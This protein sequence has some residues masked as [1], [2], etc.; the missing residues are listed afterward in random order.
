M[1][2]LY[3][4]I[5][6]MMTSCLCAREATSDEDRIFQLVAVSNRS[7]LNIA[8]VEEITSSSSGDEMR[9]LIKRVFKP[10]NGD[11]H[12]YYFRSAF[13]GIAK[14][15]DEPEIFHDSLILMVNSEG[16]I[17]DGFSYT[18]EWAE[19][20]LY[21]DLYRIS[22]R[23]LAFSSLKCVSQ[24]NFRPAIQGIGDFEAA[25]RGVVDH[26]KSALISVENE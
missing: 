13:W 3:L 26:S 5:I 15:R 12:V 21:C 16:V 22:I 9:R 24:L 8:L 17:T 23:G 1:K 20:P 11:S 14:F 25:F 7:A 4:I 6:V 10:V 2:A 19:M 18:E